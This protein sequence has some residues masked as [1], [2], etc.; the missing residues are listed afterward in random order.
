MTLL[1]AHVFH[2]LDR[3]FEVRAEISDIDPTYLEAVVWSDNRLA[4][5]PC[6]DGGEMFLTYGAAFSNTA[7]SNRRRTAESLIETAE[8][9]HRRRTTAQAVTEA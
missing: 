7:G 9:D 6:P 4:A 8:R 2:H 3:T 5:V 1:T